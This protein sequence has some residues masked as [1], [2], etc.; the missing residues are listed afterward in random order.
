MRMSERIGRRHDGQVR[1]RKC[2]DG[3]SGSG[4]GLALHAEQ[5]PQVCGSGDPKDFGFD[6]DCASHQA[7]LPSRKAVVAWRS[8]THIPAGSGRTDVQWFRHMSPSGGRT[9][10]REKSTLWRKLSRK[11]SRRRVGRRDPM[12]GA[13][14]PPAVAHLRARRRQRTAKVLLRPLR[15]ATV[16]QTE[17]VITRGRGCGDAVYAR[18]AAQPR[19]QGWRHGARGRPK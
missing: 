12:T 3:Y 18:H 6:P 1:R 4:H 19:F 15:Q 17:E 14:V 8:P 9:L 11:K 5:L 16:R 2:I 7:R 13:I 10:R